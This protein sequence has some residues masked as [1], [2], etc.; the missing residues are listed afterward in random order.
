[1]KPT[2][3]SRFRPSLAAVFGILLLSSCHTH[4]EQIAIDYLRSHAKSPSSFK[5]I[6][7][8][9]H[10]YRPDTTESFDTAY[11]Y[12]GKKIY[13][14]WGENTYDSLTITRSYYENSPATW[15]DIT[16]EASNAFGVML[17]G[18]ESIIVRSGRANTLIDDLS[19]R[20]RKTLH[21]S[22]KFPAKQS[23]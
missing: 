19:N 7:C 16:Y 10:E 14:E 17:K 11:Y 13:P 20:S 8:E 23:L 4:D 1:M 2:H 3:T 18:Q 5:V 9:S 15:V 21:H 12:N 6:E 22:E